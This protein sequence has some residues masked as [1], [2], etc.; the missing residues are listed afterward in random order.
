MV[1]KRADG[2]G[3]ELD[4]WESEFARSEAS[5]G[6]GVGSNTFVHVP[7]GHFDLEL[8]RILWSPTISSLCLMFDNCTDEAVLRRSISGLK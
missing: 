8:F 1:L 5:A 4:A 3:E 7:N 6:E 2:S